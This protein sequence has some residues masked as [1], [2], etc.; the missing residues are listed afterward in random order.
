MS[1]SCMIYR[2]SHGQV[3]D[4]NL[5]EEYKEPDYTKLTMGCHCLVKQEDGIWQPG[6]VS[7]IVEGHYQV[8]LSSVNKDVAAGPEELWPLSEDD[9]T[10][11]GESDNESDMINDSQSDQPIVRTLITVSKGFGE[12]EKHTSV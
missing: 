3:V 1:T 9:E 2:N 6:T 11:S 12:W 7:A 8:T 5:L 10:R 4:F